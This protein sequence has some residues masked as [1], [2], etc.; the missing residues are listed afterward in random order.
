MTPRMTEQLERKKQRLERER[1]AK[2]KHVEHLNA[3]CNHGKELLATN[4]NAQERVM[5][6]G[7]PVLAFHATTEKEE[8]RN[9]WRGFQKSVC[10]L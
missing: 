9:A 3:I 1:R 2:H 8:Q 6:L 5:Q 10:M 7:R 4:R